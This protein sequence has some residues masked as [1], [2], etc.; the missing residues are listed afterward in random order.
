MRFFNIDSDSELEAA[1]LN[2][3]AHARSGVC[4]NG[5]LEGETSVPVIIRWFL[6]STK[7]PKLSKKSAPKMGWKM[8]AIVKVHVIGLVK[9]ERVNLRVSVPKV[10]IAELLAARSEPD[11]MVVR[12]KDFGRI[13]RHEPVSMRK[14]I[15]VHEVLCR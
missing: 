15:L 10:G 1:Q 9:V 3:V 5:R 12:A 13:D 8:S 11:G 14:E 2:T 7:K 6:Q 4:L